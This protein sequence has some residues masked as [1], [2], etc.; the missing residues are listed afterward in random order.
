M[1]N[2]TGVCP[3]QLAFRPSWSREPMGQLDDAKGIVR[4]KNRF[5]RILADYFVD[6]VYGGKIWWNVKNPGEKRPGVPYLALGPDAFAKPVTPEIPAFQAFQ[7]LQ[8]LDDDARSSMTAPRSREGEVDLNKATAAFL[9]RAQGQLSDVVRSLQK[10]YAWAKQNA[11]EAAFAQDEAWCNAKKTIT[12]IA[13]GRRFETTYTPTELIDGDHQ[14]RVSYGTSSGLD[15]ATHNILELQKLAQNVMSTETFLENDPGTEDVP[16]EM[17]RIR[18]GML[19]DSIM[20]GLLVP[21]TPLEQRA[22]AL[23]LFDEGKT[24]AQVA[25]ALHEAAAPQATPPIPGIPGTGAPAPTPGGNPLAPT[26]N[27][28][29]PVLPPV[30]ALQQVARPR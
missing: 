25:K 22:L 15:P 4:A 14:N 20:Q 9:S 30:A 7:V 26:A 3:L 11:N 18:G 28:Q 23:T 19:Q 17:A 6:M 2:V 21:T 16:A 10:Q 12:G 8:E 29:P 24:V 27:E 1:E 13:R 5:F